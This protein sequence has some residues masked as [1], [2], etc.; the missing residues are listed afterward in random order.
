MNRNEKQI[1][2]IIK[3]VY[4][5]IIILL[6]YFF[7]KYLLGPLSPFLSAFIIVAASRKIISSIERVSHSKKYASVLFTA[8]LIIILSL[9][10]YA[11]S[12]GFFK[13]LSKLSE[14]LS[15]DRISHYL[16][17]IS[18]KVSSF[19]DSFPPL[20]IFS[21][22]FDYAVK[23]IENLD[24]YIIKYLSDTIPSI[25]SFS[26]KFLSIF[27]TAV[28]FLGF[29][30]IAIFYI[31]HDYDKICSFIL[32]QLPEKTLETIDE[33]KNVIIS[34]ARELFKSY[35]LLTLITFF[36]LLAGFLI[37]GI[38]YS[39]LLA[40]LICFVDLLPILGTGSVL[41]PWAVFCFFTDNVSTAAG[42]IVLYAVITVFR[43][44][45]EPKIV[46]NNIGLHPLLSLI[47]IFLGIKLIGF[48]GIIIFPILTITVISLNRKGFIKLYK[49][50]PENS[51]DKI[52]K[53]RKKFLDF[54][55]S[56]NIHSSSSGGDLHDKNHE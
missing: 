29:M 42:L 40:S 13:E 20:G 11:I 41:I 28:I 49:N 8:S 50:F 19:K 39:L 12:F 45:A 35:F 17:M 44:I 53:T 23:G 34:T 24:E 51:T 56:E 14:S 21:K 10:L 32:L 15:E 48:S 1:A 27:P 55:R 22:F 38:D 16:D 9:L 26:V 52:L 4:C 47:S 5:F 30:F 7:I 36:Q 6:V 43:N 54:K 18:L 25:L 46:G 37:L 31:S 3:S 2:F 33:T